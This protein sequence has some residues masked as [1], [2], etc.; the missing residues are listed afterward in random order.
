MIL[1]MKAHLLHDVY[2]TDRAQHEFTSAINMR[3]LQ[4]ATR[5]SGD[6]SGTTAEGGG[7]TQTQRTD[8]T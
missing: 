6:D 8:L 7:P 2:I 3:T 1:N 5:D 4:F